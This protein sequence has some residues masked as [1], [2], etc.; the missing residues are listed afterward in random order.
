MS[1]DGLRIAPYGGDGPVPAG[2]VD[3]WFWLRQWADPPRP[4]VNIV[5]A[6]GFSLERPPR[7]WR[8]KLMAEAGPRP[9]DGTVWRKTTAA[10]GSA[11]GF[12]LYG[13]GRYPAEEG[14]TIHDR[15]TIIVQY[16]TTLDAAASMLNR[17]LAFASFRLLTRT[18]ATVEPARCRV[19][20]ERI[21]AAARLVADPQSADDVRAI[22]ADI[23]RAALEWPQGPPAEPEGDRLV[24]PARPAGRLGGGDMTRSLFD[25]IDLDPPP[26]PEPPAI[27]F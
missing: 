17:C 15:T 1:A 16:Q 12:K 6:V 7:G 9:G 23:L 18:A 4:P 5:T 27:T 2:M 10:E 25:G 21:E 26:D 8:V 24:R 13:V 3:V 11:S 22:T 20:I 19:A 14:F